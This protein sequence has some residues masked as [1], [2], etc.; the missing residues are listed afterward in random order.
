MT[1]LL[2]SLLGAGCKSTDWLRSRRLPNTPLAVPMKL[3]SWSG[4]QP[5]P[6]TLQWLRRYD[7]VDALDEE[8]QELVAKV[9]QIVV[10]RPS[11]ENVYV[12]SELAFLSGFGAIEASPKVAAYVE[13]IEARPAYQASFADFWKTVGKA[14][15]AS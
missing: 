1:L 2:A 4:P 10:A 12:M 9:N 15:P 13:R 7:L 14:G 3:F 6:R 8:P 11:A 5:S